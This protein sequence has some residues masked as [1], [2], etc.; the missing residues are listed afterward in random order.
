MLFE[1]CCFEIGISFVWLCVLTNLNSLQMHQHKGGFKWKCSTWENRLKLRK[2]AYPKANDIWWAIHV[3]KYY[4]QYSKQKHSD[5]TIKE[6]GTKQKKEYFYKQRRLSQSLECAAVQS[7]SKLKKKNEIQKLNR[8][9]ME[10]YM[11]RLLKWSRENI[12]IMETITRTL[13]S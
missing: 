3:P 5:G 7:F 8:F 13:S 10:T 6:S 9:F 1:R 12:D 4:S 2:K 11:F